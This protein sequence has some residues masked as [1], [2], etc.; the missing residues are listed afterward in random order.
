M[1]GWKCL[2]CAKRWDGPAV[3]MVKDERGRKQAKLTE[4][5]EAVKLHVLTFNHSCAP[6]AHGG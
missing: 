1:K 2:D 6:E 4:V 3:E 5:G